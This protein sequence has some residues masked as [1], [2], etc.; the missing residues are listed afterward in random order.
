MTPNLQTDSDS[1]L[2]RLIKVEIRQLNTLPPFRIYYW[3][4]EQYIQIEKKVASK[5]SSG[6]GVPAGLSVF[7]LP[8]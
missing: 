6:K 8:V 5:S 3:K 1:L 2:L 7:K 4:H